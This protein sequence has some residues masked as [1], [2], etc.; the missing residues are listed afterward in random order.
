MLGL[1]NNSLFEEKEHLKWS[2]LRHK[3][4]ETMYQTMQGEV[5]PFIKNLHEDQNSAYSKYMDDAIFKERGNCSKWRQFQ[6]EFRIFLP[7]AVVHVNIAYYNLAKKQ[8]GSVTI[9]AKKLRK[10]LSDG[11][12]KRDLPIF[13]FTISLIV[14]NTLSCLIIYHSINR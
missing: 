7:P 6:L 10:D 12:K 11:E 14:L 5:F 13:R 4:A 8:M 2:A 9:E 1:A 3:P